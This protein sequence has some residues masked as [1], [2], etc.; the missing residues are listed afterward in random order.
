M[1]CTERP[2]GRVI[3]QELPH[4]LVFFSVQ[5]LNVVEDV[6]LH[7]EDGD[8]FLLHVGSGKYYGLNRP[9]LVVWKA[10]AD[11]VDPVGRLVAKWPN[12]PA[13]ALRADAEVLVDQLLKA[14]LIRDRAA[15]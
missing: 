1:V 14:G 2:N 7:E 8:A 11:G 5:A 15:S 9:G 3:A 13:E 6:I 10:L 12:R 4:A